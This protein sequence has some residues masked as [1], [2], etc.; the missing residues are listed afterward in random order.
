MEEKLFDDEVVS[1]KKTSSAALSG[2]KAPDIWELTWEECLAVY[3]KGGSIVSWE[4]H[5]LAGR[6]RDLEKM[7]QKQVYSYYLNTLEKA[8]KAGKEI[9]EV[10]QQNEPE[11]FGRLREQNAA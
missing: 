8:F 6:D 7:G 11:L 9:P 5:I 10:V 2:N 3:N 4:G 1:P